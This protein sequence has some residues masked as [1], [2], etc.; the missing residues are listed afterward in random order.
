MAKLLDKNIFTLNKV[1]KALVILDIFLKSPTKNTL[2][3]EL[4]IKL[5]CTSSLYNKIDINEFLDNI[6]II[7]AGSKEILIQEIIRSESEKHDDYLN[8]FLY[9]I[10]SNENLTYLGWDEFKTNPLR[11]KFEDVDGTIAHTCDRFKYID[12]PTSYLRDSEEETSEEKLRKQFSYEGII[13]A[14]AEGIFTLEGGSLIE[15]IKNFSN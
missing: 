12:I 13:E 14:T 1:I 7:G 3:A 5:D 11:I 15:K 6:K 4:L 10:T 8:K 9:L 2:L